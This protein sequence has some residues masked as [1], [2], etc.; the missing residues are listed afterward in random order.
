VFAQLVCGYFGLPDL[1]RPL[2]G[3]LWRWRTGGDA[4]GWLPC[5]GQC[6]WGEQRRVID[7]RE[8]RR[9]CYAA[10]FLREDGTCVMA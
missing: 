5:D 6:G 9:R 10:G 2:T 4:Q 3:A 8:Q 1:L 7:G